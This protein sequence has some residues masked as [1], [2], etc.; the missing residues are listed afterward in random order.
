VHPWHDLTLS[1]AAGVDDVSHVCREGVPGGGASFL[2]R[3]APC[4][5]RKCS[6]TQWCI[7][8]TLSERRPRSDR[9]CS[10]L[11]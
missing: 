4:G 11:C 10:L 3:C 8:T 7:Y 1:R 9:W 6:G 2:Y 5:F